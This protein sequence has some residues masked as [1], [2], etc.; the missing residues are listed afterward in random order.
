MKS[1]TQPGSLSKLAAKTF[2][3]T[4]HEEGEEL[5]GGSEDLGTI[6]L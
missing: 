5:L 6:I 2:Q 1:A 4:Q 3:A